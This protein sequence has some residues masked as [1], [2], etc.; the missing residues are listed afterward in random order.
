MLDPLLVGIALHLSKVCK[1]RQVRMRC[2]AVVALVEV[3]GQDLPV[4]VTLHAVLMIQLIVLK[5]GVCKSV[6]LI[7]GVEV[8]GP[9]LRVIRAV[10]VDPDEAIAIKLEMDLE[11]TVLALVETFENVV[12]GRLGKVAAQTVRPTVVLA[13]K[14]GR[15]ALSSSLDNWKGSVTADVVKGV[16][17]ALPVPGNN[18]LVACNVEL[19]PISCLG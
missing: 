7:N 17:A 19:E 1:R 14:D 2:G 16:Q 6:L 4:V 11:K 12:V 9:R 8:L 3:I 15:V 10:E 5:V 18:E 13:G